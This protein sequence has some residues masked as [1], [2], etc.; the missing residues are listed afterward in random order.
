MNLILTVDS[1][2]PVPPFEQLR[3]QIMDQ[4]SSGERL[5]GARLPTVRQLAGE[6]G[7][8]AGTVARTY[9]ELEGSGVIE[10]RGR[11]GTF[12]SPH[13][14]VVHQEAQRAATAFAE[15]IRTLGLTRAEALALA[16]AALR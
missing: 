12:V 9:R 8:A 15:R 14:D 1:D 7:V 3:S 2:S 4:I 13:G 6:L 11:N 10:T 5:A 16:E